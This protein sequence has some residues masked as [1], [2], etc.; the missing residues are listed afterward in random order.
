MKRKKTIVIGSLCCLGLCSI[1]V[2]KNL[3][4]IKADSS[5]EIP[6]ADE[7]LFPEEEV[8][9]KY[10]EDSLYVQMNNKLVKAMNDY[11]DG[12]ISEEEYKAICAEIS[13]VVNDEDNL[14]RMEQEEDEFNKVEGEN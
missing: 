8:P 3:D 4:F 5:V 11:E 14:H 7:E 6:R 13:S 1:L 10:E 2:L 12:K 9:V